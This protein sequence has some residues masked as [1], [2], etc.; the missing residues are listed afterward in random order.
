ANALEQVLAR[1]PLRARYLVAQIGPRLV[2][3]PEERRDPAE[4]R[5]QDRDLEFAIPLEHTLE[6]EAGELRLV[7]G[8]AVHALLGVVARIAGRGRRR[9]DAFAFRV[10]VDRP[11]EV[12]LDAGFVD[13]PVEG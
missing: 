6:H 5:L 12:A 7:G 1:R 4:A 2:H 3:A 13:R 10:E 8:R 11:D 9:V